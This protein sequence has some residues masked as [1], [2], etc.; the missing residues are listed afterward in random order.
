MHITNSALIRYLGLK[1]SALEYLQEINKIS[2]SSQIT[3]QPTHAPHAVEKSMLQ[4]LLSS[5]D[6]FVALE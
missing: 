5:A 3:M 6:T 1:Q 2:I 4:K